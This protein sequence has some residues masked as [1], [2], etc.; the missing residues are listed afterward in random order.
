MQFGF[1]NVAPSIG[2]RVLR[3]AASPFSANER[4]KEA[5]DL[6]STSSR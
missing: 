6:L 1:V 5:P 2:M 4:W 3:S